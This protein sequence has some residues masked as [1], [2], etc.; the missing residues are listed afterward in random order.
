MRFFITC[1][2]KLTSKGCLYD[3]MHKIQSLDYLKKSTH[4]HFGTIFIRLFTSLIILSA[5]TFSIHRKILPPGEYG[6]VTS[7]TSHVIT[8]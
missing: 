5:S 8:L 2:L 6:G 4:S 3:Y 7:W 1:G